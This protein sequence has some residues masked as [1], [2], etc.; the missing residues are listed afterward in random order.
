MR[1]HTRVSSPEWKQAGFAAKERMH[2]LERSKEM[3]NEAREK[4]QKAAT[5]K[6]GGK[7]LKSGTALL[8]ITSPP[9]MIY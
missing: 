8:L 5:K 7:F 6:G 1:A 4:Y 3:Y 2:D 9:A